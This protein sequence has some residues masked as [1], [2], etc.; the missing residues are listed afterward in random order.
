MK[1]ILLLLATVFL[2]FSGCKESIQD[3]GDLDFLTENDAIIKIN[4]ASVYPDDR[5]MYVKFNDE[6]V[7]PLIRA[8]EPYP[9][10][11]YN[12]RGDSRPDFLKVAAGTINVKVC[13]PHKK[14]NGQDSIVLNDQTLSVEGGKQ[15]TIHITDTAAN[16]K[17]FLAQE[18]FVKPDSS[19]ATYRF[20]NLM[21]NVEAIDLYYGAAPSTTTPPV[22]PTQDSLIAKNIKF[23]EISEY[24]T[25]R[26]ATTRSWKIRRAGA[27][28]THET[29]LAFYTNASSTL[30]KRSYV[31]YA[32]GY[33]G[34]T[35][36][37]MKPYISFYLVR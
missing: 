3:F 28:A 32:L 15:Y 12:T 17:M 16:T 31:A 27:P 23:G 29:V 26:R 11:G 36:T 25:I 19:F 22:Q 9:G 6:R 13:I 20:V 37:I 18:S 21:P 1:K 34:F 35:S 33:A 24:F 5:Y 14:D 8:R 7:T 10:G 30:D 4:M 2:A